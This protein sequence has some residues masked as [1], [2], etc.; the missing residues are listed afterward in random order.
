LSENCSYHIL[1]A[2]EVANPRFELIRRVGWP[3]IPAD[4]MKAIQAEP[5]LVRTIQFRPSNRAQAKARLARLSPRERDALSDV[6]SDGGTKAI[7]A[8]DPRGKARVLDAALDL[9]DFR[10]ARD[11]VRDPGEAPDPDGARLKQRLLEE[12]AQLLLESEDLRLE[13][14]FRKM[15]HVGH[16]S[17]RLGL[18]SGHLE[19]RGYYYGLDLRLALHDLADSAPGYPDEAAIEFM[20]MRFRYYLEDRTFSLE[21]LNLVQVTSLTPLERFL[22]KW[23]WTVSFGA[24]RVRD[25]GCEGCLAVNGEFG[26][27]FSLAPFGDALLWWALAD[28]RI[29]APVDGGVFDAVRAGIGPKSGLRLRLADRLALLGVGSLHFLPAQEPEYTWEAQGVLRWFYA[30]DFAI[31]VDTRVQPDALAVQGFSYIYF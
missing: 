12:R 31:S 15:P 16:D 28:A 11:L 30:R 9:V 23:S 22:K 10:Y 6:V 20:P 18:G 19:G 5:G 4:T 29:L 2:L 13:P 25:D 3:V 14:P 17:S 24:T 21:E 26:A 1:A 8:F 27:G 7:A